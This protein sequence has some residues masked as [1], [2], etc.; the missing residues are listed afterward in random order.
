M[1][2]IFIRILCTTKV[3]E[4]DENN[5]K[6]A[7]LESKPWMALFATNH[8][9]LTVRLFQNYRFSQHKCLTIDVIIIH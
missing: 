4:A 2:Y 9:Y 1:F 8:H 3:V 7:C 6:R 5:L